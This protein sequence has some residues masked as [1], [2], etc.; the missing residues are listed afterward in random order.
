MCGEPRLDELVLE[1]GSCLR[2]HGD[3]TADLPQLLDESV[4][5]RDGFGLER[6]EGACTRAFPEEL[7]HLACK[8]PRQ[9][10]RSGSVAFFVT[11]APARK[12]ARARHAAVRINATRPGTF[13][14]DDRMP[15]LSSRPRSI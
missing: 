10:F 7:I 9:G 2:R 4:C 6:A 15:S 5:D 14:F 8:D 11:Q 3:R 13:P 12:Q 1:L